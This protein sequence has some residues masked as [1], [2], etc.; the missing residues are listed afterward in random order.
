MPLSASP[1]P[2]LIAPTATT[3]NVTISW[4]FSPNEIQLEER[5]YK[6]G[7]TATFQ[8]R[9]IPSNQ[10]VVGSYTQALTPGDV[11]EVRAFH[12]NFFL[13][14]N[15]T[16]EEKD[17]HKLDQ[18]VVHALKSPSTLIR[19]VAEKVGGTFYRASVTTGSAAIGPILTHGIMEVGK[20]EPSPRTR[21]AFAPCR[22][23]S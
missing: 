14:K 3:D 7:S 4:N 17:R 16:D 22:T 13:G 18:V 5:T 11:Y 10:L 6:V 23:R 9:P 12:R 1:D 20:D 15:A 19:N 8:P 21:L 2:V